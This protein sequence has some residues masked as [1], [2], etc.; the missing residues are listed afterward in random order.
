MTTVLDLR[1]AIANRT[2]CEFLSPDEFLQR[3]TSHTP[4]ERCD[5]P[6]ANLAGL[7]NKMTGRRYFVPVEELNRS[8]IKR[9]QNP[10]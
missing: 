9:P 3:L 7:R 2:D 5:E 4:V 1:N 10:Q 6:D 8:G